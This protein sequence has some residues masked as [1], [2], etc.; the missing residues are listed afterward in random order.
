MSRAQ[1]GSVCGYAKGR[2]RVRLEVL[3][4]RSGF[5]SAFRGFITQGWNLH[6]D[7]SQR[8]SFCD[9]LRRSRLTDGQLIGLSQRICNLKPLNLLPSA[10]SSSQGGQGSPGG[11]GQH[12]GQDHGVRHGR[13]LPDDP[14]A[15]VSGGEGH[16]EPHSHRDQAGAK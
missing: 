5:S 7:S 16:L 3:Y 2:L 10:F 8:T 1:S 13:L 12:P 15:H 9:R 6:A 11:P 4:L 14:R